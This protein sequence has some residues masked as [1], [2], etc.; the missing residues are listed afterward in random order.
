MIH[1][2]HYQQHYRSLLRLGFPIMVGQVAIVFLGFVDN[3]M[4]GQHAMEELSAASFVNNFL[5]LILI[6][7]LGFSYG[8]TP[9]TAEADKL[10]NRGYAG[11]LLRTSLRLNL[12]LGLLLS[13]IVLGLSPFLGIFN[14]DA[15]L[16]PIALP[17][18]YLQTLSF[19]ISMAFNAFKQFFDGMSRTQLP[20]YTT[21]VGIAVNVLFN[22][23]LIY[24]KLGFPEWGLFGAGVAT[25]LSR[26][27][28]LVVLIG[29]FWLERDWL[30]IRKAFFHS[31][32]QRESIRALIRLGSPIS[33]QLGLEAAS[34]SLIIVFVAKLGTLSLAAHQVVMVVTLLGYL[35]YYGLGAATT[36]RVSHFKAMNDYNE[37]QRT[38]SAATHIGL[39]IAVFAA[40]VMWVIRPY[41]TALF[42]PDKEVSLL[43]SIAL[44]PVII[45][46][47]ADV[48]QVI[49]SNALRGLEQVKMLA[50]IAF[51]SHIV[52]SPI[53]SYLFT[54]H[55]AK[56]Y[57]LYQLMAV[58]SS[59]PISL[60]VMGYLLYRYFNKCIVRLRR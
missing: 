35:I 43:V 49:Y 7:G 34:F 59:F 51:L 24:G 11:Q 4:V 26:V 3:M 21:L 17:Y 55:I 13:V 25:L 1:F 38:A 30:D 8:L 6:F 39:V 57:P 53:L 41:V 9:L 56:D 54:F 12:I 33:L 20:M 16:R 60:A 22:Y 15:E 27:A 48:I 47:F 52:V 46:Q 23:L 36:I 37:A 50:P 40:F 14:L 28:M 18:Y 29:A 19:F 45:Y 5:N 2:S 31:S 32:W 42:T 44:W 10:N 58:W